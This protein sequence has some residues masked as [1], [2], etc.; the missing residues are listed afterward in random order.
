MGSM[1]DF[2][3]LIQGRTA[4]LKAKPEALT[5]R[6]A[7]PA[8]GDQM[9]FQTPGRTHESTFTVTDIRIHDGTWTVYL[10]MDV[11]PGRKKQ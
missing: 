7:F 1:N 8:V 3:V 9:T 5:L 2:E 6:G 4:I 10:D 11:E